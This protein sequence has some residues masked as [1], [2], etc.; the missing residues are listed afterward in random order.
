MSECGC[1]SVCEYMCLCVCDGWWHCEIIDK[2]ED[3][4]LQGSQ[5]E[6][7]VFRTGLIMTVGRL[8]CAEKEDKV[9]SKC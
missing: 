8:I 1:V 6:R 4:S 5:R 3:L 7:Y 2:T 9:I